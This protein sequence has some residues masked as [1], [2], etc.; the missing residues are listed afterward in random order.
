VIT[1]LHMKDE[2]IE[3]QVKVERM[4]LRALLSLKR[5][6]FPVDQQELYAQARRLATRN[7]EVSIEDIDSLSDEDVEELVSVVGD[8][9]GLA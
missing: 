5:E 6:S 2:E 1:C 8:V 7:G 4:L 3:Q 9:L